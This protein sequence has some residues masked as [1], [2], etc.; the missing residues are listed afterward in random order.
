MSKAAFFMAWILM[1]VASII[2]LLSP[3]IDIAT[4]QHF[5]IAPQHFVLLNEIWARGARTVLYNLFTI[6]LIFLAGWLVFKLI[7]PSLQWRTKSFF[8]IAIAMILVPFLLVNIVLKDGVGRPRPRDII[9]F[10]G[11]KIYQPIWHISSECSSNCSFVCGDSSVV[12]AFWVFL[13]YFRKR[14]AKAAYGFFV[15]LAGIFYGYVRI[16]QGAHFLSDVI[17]SSLIS[18]IGIYSVWWFFYIYSPRWLS[19]NALQHIVELANS[20]LKHFLGVKK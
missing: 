4:T 13:P 18:Y 9:E 3:H 15:L 2:F 7:R 11:T 12:F 16:G 1:G 19:E 5:F 6:F 10:G 20:K 8:Y 17:F 14:Y